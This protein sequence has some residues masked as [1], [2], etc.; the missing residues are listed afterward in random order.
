VV[1]RLKT[2]LEATRLHIALRCY[3]EEHGRLPGRLDELAPRYIER[4]PLDP[5]NGKPFRY[6]PKRALLYSVGSN[7]RDDGGKVGKRR[8]E[9]LDIVYP[10]EFA[11]GRGAGG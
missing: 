8:W 9:P 11:S 3:F 6:D 1:C 7:R 4:V 2:D 5:F 10:L